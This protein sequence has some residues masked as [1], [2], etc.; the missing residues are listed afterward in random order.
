MIAEK[1]DTA[2]TFEEV[3]FFYNENK[4]K[5]I[6]KENILK[7]RYAFIDVNAPNLSNFESSERGDSGFGSSGKK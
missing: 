5:F 4:N 6:L 2:V 1:M 7:L 3:K